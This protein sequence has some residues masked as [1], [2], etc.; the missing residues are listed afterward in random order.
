MSMN[1]AIIQCR[2]TRDPE[3]RTTPTGKPVC[4]FTIAWSEKVKDSEQQLFQPC[5]AWDK[6]AE[7]VAKHFQKG[8]EVIVEG[9]LVT[10]KWQDK[11]GNNRET[12]ELILDRIHFTGKKEEQRG[13]QGHGGYSGGFISAPDL[14]D[15]DGLPF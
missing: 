7:F 3:L 9:K 8:Q 11:Q 10:R 6:N 2:L 4:G 14:A 13:S 1:R 15:E 12:N 5:V